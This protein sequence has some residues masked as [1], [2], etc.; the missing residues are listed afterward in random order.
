MDEDSGARGFPPGGRGGQ[1]GRLVAPGR[2][3]AQVG[4]QVGNDVAPLGN[5]QTFLVVP[6]ER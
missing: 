4:R 5:S 3:R 6:L 2:Y 1:Q